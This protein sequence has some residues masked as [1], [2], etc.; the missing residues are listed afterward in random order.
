M[1]DPSVVKKKTFKFYDN[2]ILKV[3]KTVSNVGITLDSRTQMN[4]CLMDISRYIGR[5]A[6]DLTKE[7]GKRT[8]SDRDIIGAF[9]IIFL[10]DKEFLEK[11]VEECELACKSFLESESKSSRQMKAGIIFAPSVCEKFLR[12]FDYNKV[13][14]TKC[15]PVCMA[16]GLE[17][18]TMNILVK[19][20]E[21]L[22]KNKHKRLTI[23]DIDRGVKGDDVLCKLFRRV[24]ITFIDGTCKEFIH[25]N[26]LSNTKPHK[27]KKDDKMQYQQGALSL[28]NMRELQ[29]EGM[30]LTIPKFS[31]EQHMRSILHVMF[32]G[33]NI[34]ISKSVFMIL[35]H[36]IESYMV[37]I[38]SDVNDISIHSKR[39]KVL[40]SDI[41]LAMKLKKIRVEDYESYLE[42]VRCSG[43]ATIDECSDEENEK[44]IIIFE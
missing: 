40:Q 4:S 21:S 39:V 32:P 15:A 3:L 25:P 18:I 43:C 33:E 9:E 16:A 42:D 7:G 34:K 2:Y 23:K 29:R 26:L 28:K 10:K 31:F 8:V 44:K 30:T 27:K 35:Q 37:N 14:I 38:L 20:V 13:M 5:V 12:D 11:L 6:F 24:N 22:E 17:F 36:Y 19:G 1:S 41:Q